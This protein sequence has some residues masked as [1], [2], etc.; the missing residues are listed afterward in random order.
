M[1]AH[2]GLEHNKF[3]GMAL[4]CIIMFFSLMPFFAYLEF[5]QVIGARELRALLFGGPREAADPQAKAPAVQLLN[6]PPAE[7]AKPRN[8]DEVRAT[9]ARDQARENQ[10]NI[11]THD[12]LW[13]YEQAG[14]VMGPV[15]GAELTRLL[16][17]GVIRPQTL[18]YTASRGDQWRTLNESLPI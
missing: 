14:E 10:Q 7:R 8:E 11:E 5:E 12:D 9:A 2:P 16:R 15:G 13:F 3:L 1:S 6:A 17:L 4:V 18:V